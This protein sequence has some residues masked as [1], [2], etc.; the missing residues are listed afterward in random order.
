MK[1]FVWRLQRVLDI[2]KKE[3]QKAR[4]ELLELTERLAQT[5]GELLMQQKM[6]EDIINALTGEN[7]KKRLGKQ[8]FFLKFSAASDEQIKKLKDKVNELELQ[9]RDKIA[10]VL[11]LRRFKE[12]LEKLR[13]E[14]KM[15]FIKEQ[16]RLEQKQLDEGATVSFVRRA[17]SKVRS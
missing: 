1:R 17:Q 11:K 8:E 3:E 14:A 9:Q 10:E 16:E 15:R 13:T 5:R 7:L 12:G 4:A 2:R 6:L